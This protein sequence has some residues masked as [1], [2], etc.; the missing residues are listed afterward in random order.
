MKKILL[1]F[2]FLT[3]VPVK[4]EGEISERDIGRASAFFP[5]VG[6]FQGLLLVVA[7]IVFT[8][9][10]P[11]ELTNGLLMLVLILTNGGLHL[12]GLSDTFDA[13]ASRADRNKKLSIM[14]DS[15]AGP[16]GV[17]AIVLCILLKY[18][19]LNVLFFNLPLVTYYLSLFLMPVFSKW[20]M[21][22]SAFHGGSAR[23]DG[24]GRIF[25]ENTRGQELRMAG[26]L[27]V[28]F[29]LMAVLIN[30]KMAGSLYHFLIP[31]LTLYIFSRLSVGFF[32]KRFGGL[33]GDTLGAVS[34]VSEV[35]FPLVMICI[36]KF[37]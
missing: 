16:F 24:L 33:T 14:K 27:L 29:S 25:I 28:L 35:I 7:S 5:I 9:L 36:Q 4:V 13:I 10:F 22:S 15:T 12:D 30:V 2:Q 11:H 20:A 18:L 6:A 26:F 8:R 21:V 1:A 19:T 3:I 34:E 32:K 17:I 37:I 23:Q 31:M